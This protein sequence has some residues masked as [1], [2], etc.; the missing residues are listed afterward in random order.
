M[1]AAAAA[2]GAAALD[3]ALKTA[4][5][6][7]QSGFNFLQNK[8]NYEKQVALMEL[9]NKYNVENWQA[10]NEYNTPLEQLRRIQQAGLSSAQ[11]YGGNSSQIAG[12]SNSQPSGVTMPQYHGI[13]GVAPDLSNIFNS[14]LQ[15]AQKKKIDAETENINAN[16]ENTSVETKFLNDTYSTRSDGIKLTNQQILKSVESISEQIKQTAANTANLHQQNKL[17]VQNEFINSYEL[18]LKKQLY[19]YNAEIQPLLIKFQ[20]LANNR[21]ISE[22]YKNQSQTSLNKSNYALNRSNIDVNIANQKKINK[23]MSLI[24]EKIKNMTYDN[25]EQAALRALAQQKDHKSVQLLLMRK[26]LGNDVVKIGTQSVGNMLNTVVDN[27]TSKTPVKQ[28]YHYH[29]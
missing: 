24:S 29:Y 2:V 7:L 20:K 9:Q 21:T 25:L 4:Q 10:N 3:T 1:S 6:T 22:I 17:M 14:A 11:V 18:E 13:P 26:Q 8:K 5:S 15:I 27:A 12:V 23:E 28:S 19:Y 16:T